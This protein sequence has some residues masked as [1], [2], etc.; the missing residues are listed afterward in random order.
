MGF[1]GFYS[2]TRFLGQ[3]LPSVSLGRVPFFCFTSPVITFIYITHTNSI[4]ET[5]CYNLYTD[6]I[7]CASALTLPL[8]LN[9]VPKITKKTKC[10]IVSN[11]FRLQT[12]TTTTLLTGACLF[13][14]SPFIKSCPSHALLSYEDTFLILVSDI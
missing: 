2:W 11:P 14:I 3:P 13:T 8:L 9:F 1:Y 4:H 10:Y 6:N 7:L 5:I 12:A